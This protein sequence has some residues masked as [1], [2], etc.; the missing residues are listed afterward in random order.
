MQVFEMRQDD[1]YTISHLF[2]M[3]KLL[4]ALKKPNLDASLHFNNV[5][6]DYLHKQCNTH[7]LLQIRYAI[8]RPGCN[9]IYRNRLLILPL[10]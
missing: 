4:A 10:S 7:I 2:R 6:K 3:L 9:N 5:S 1:V 8:F